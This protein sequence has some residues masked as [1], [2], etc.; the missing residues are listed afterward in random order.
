ML[1]QNCRNLHSKPN[2]NQNFEGKFYAVTDVHSRTL[3]SAGVLT[4]IE[5]RCAD[6]IPATFLD[7]GDFTSGLYSNGAT[8][9]IY[10]KFAERNPRISTVCNLGNCEI[11]NFKNPEKIDNFKTYVKTLTDSGIQVLCSAMDFL[12]QKF[13]TKV[14][15]TK[16]YTIIH[17][18]ADGKTQKILIAGTT[19]ANDNTVIKFQE[20]KDILAA[21]LPK[22]IKEHRP[23]KIILLSHNFVPETKKLVRYLKKELKIDNLELVIG[24]HPHS[25][26]DETQNATRILYPPV[27]GKGAYE[28]DHT[29]KGFE[30][31]EISRFEIDH[32]NYES[33]DANGNEVIKNHKIDY[34]APIHPAYKEVISEKEPVDMTEKIVTGFHTFQYRTRGKFASES[35]EL[36][37]FIGNALRDQT[38][39][40][41]GMLLT[42]DLREKLPKKGEQISLYN[43]KDTLNVNKP[44][45][46]LHT[47]PHQILKIIKLSL[48]DQ[49]KNANNHHFMEFS[50]NIKI[51]RVVGQNSKASKIKQIYIKHRNKWIPL[52]NSKGEIR[53]QIANKTF[54]I[55]TCD[56]IAKAKRPSLN[57]F[58]KIP[59]TPY[60]NESLCTEAVFIKALKDNEHNPNFDIKRSEIIDILP[61]A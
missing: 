55:A 14:D 30:I 32:Y 13:N 41:F 33:L 52:L 49:H 17:D 11:F 22:A 31:P 36:G 12:S 45:Y 15:G 20:Q 10:A 44:V 47:K 25:L 8:A 58:K 46:I 60:Q 35:C 39:A 38:K 1:I 48:K 24:G 2:Q 42:M 7:C 34:L 3:K 26:E 37:T 16:P 18:I 29:A 4:E 57:I 5:K 53:P 19:T 21:L 54:T 59:S 56:F 6:K 27:Q 43:I 40:D 9:G 23:D 61:S 28:I 50:D 51:K